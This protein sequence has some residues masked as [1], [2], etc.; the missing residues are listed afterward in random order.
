MKSTTLI[1]LLFLTAFIHGPASVE[2]APHEQAPVSAD[3][4]LAERGA[5]ALPDVFP[6]NMGFKTL[7]S[8]PGAPNHDFD[9]PE[10]APKEQAAAGR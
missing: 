9:T 10:N 3:P 4:A 6:I 7:L 8:R 5:L 1:P 2:G